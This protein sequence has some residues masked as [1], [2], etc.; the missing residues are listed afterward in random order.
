[1]GKIR[2]KYRENLNTLA[3]SE[4]KQHIIVLGNGSDLTNDKDQKNLSKKK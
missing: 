3:Q 4:T 2:G 1:M